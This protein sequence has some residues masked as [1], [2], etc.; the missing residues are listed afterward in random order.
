MRRKKVLGL[1]LLVG[2]PLYLRRRRDAARERVH[3]SFDDGSTVTLDDDAPE[4]A[5]L[6][7]LARQGL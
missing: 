3:V 4:G 2:G 6:L 1:A 7:A 5:R